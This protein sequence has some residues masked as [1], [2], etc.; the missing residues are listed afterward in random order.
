M[1][2]LV[3]L[4]RWYCN[5]LRL[6]ASL[7]IYSFGQKTCDP[8]PLT[9]HDPLPLTRHDPSPSTRHDRPCS[10]CQQRTIFDACDLF[11]YRHL[12]YSVII[13]ERTF[14]KRYRH[15]IDRSYLMPMLIKI[16]FK[17]RHH[18]FGARLLGARMFGA[19]CTHVWCSVHACLV[20]GAGTIGARR[21]LV[22]MPWNLGHTWPLLFN[23]SISWRSTNVVYLG[24]NFWHVLQWRQLGGWGAVPPQDSPQFFSLVSSIQCSIHVHAYQT[25]VHFSTWIDF[26][27]GCWYGAFGMTAPFS[28]ISWSDVVTLILRYR[29]YVDLM[30]ILCRSYANLI[31]LSIRFQIWILVWMH[32]NTPI[33]ILLCPNFFFRVEKCDQQQICAEGRQRIPNF[34]A[35]WKGG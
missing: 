19:P 6:S 24:C 12:T 20:L 17:P 5:D 1:H 14:F 13:L 7:V 30:S 16:T 8:P 10:F 34:G 22:Q 29:S 4:V 31:I 11:I 21:T 18:M 9:R 26:N 28:G 27:K 15:L 35:C 23:Q 2:H 3:T 25:L 33:A 32:N